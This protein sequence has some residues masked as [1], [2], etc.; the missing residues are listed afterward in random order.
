MTCFGEQDIHVKEVYGFNK[1]TIILHVHHAF[2]YIFLPSL[3]DY[4]VNIGLISRVME[5]VFKKRRPN[6]L[7]PS[8]L[9]YCS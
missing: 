4:D 8:E 6:F 1:Q 9:G 5:D 3:H 7:S 2:L